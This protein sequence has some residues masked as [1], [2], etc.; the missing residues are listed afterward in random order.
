MNT[1]AFIAGIPQPKTMVERLRTA[2]TTSLLPL[3]LLLAPPAVVEAQFTYMTNNGT[4]IITGYTGPVGPVTIPSTINGQPVTAISPYAFVTR[5]MSTDV[6]P[7]II[8][9]GAGLTRVT[10]PD[11]VTIIGNHAFYDCTNLTRVTIPGSV[12][13][14][15]GEV[16]A[17]CS[18]LNAIT[19]DAL[20]SVYSSLD[21]VVFNKSQTT[22]IE[23]PAGGPG[24]YTIPGSVISI[25]DRAFEDCT[26]LTNITIPN[27]VTS[28]GGWAFS[29]CTNLT[30]A[31]IGNSVV[32]IGDW[33]FDY[34]TSLTNLTIPSSVTSIGEWAFAYCYSLAGATI[35]N[36]VTSIGNDA[37]AWCTSLTNVTIGRSVTNIGN[38]VFNFCTNLTG[39]YFEG[40]AP[41]LGGP[42]V[43]YE[44][45]KPTVYYLRGT[46]GW[47]PTFGG[48]PTAVWVQVP[49]IQTLPQ[50]Q[51]AEA[52]SAVSLRV[53]AN[54]PLPLFYSW[55]LNA[56]NLLRSG[57]NCQLELTSVRLDQSGAYT[58]VISNVLG[59][60]TSAPAML[61][62]IPPVERRPV[63]GVKVMGEAGSLLSV[64]AADFL[65]PAPNWTPL[66]SVSLTGT[67]QY[68]FD[69][70]QPLPPQRFYR[71]WQT[72]TPGVVPSLDLH[73]VPAITL[74]GTIG[75][76]VRLD[77]INQFGPT[78]AWVTLGTVSLTNA[79]QL[80][81]DV[82]APGQ[83][84]RLYRVEQMP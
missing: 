44:D 76:S 4:I 39:V 14:L 60:I 55:Y 24:S 46:T 63:P 62:V 70:T 67:P 51:T 23:Y 13:N 32:S 3:L 20:N 1:Q 57:T 33:A 83:P 17:A 56:A 61:N 69:L 27:S 38:Y 78:G 66:G 84:P 16:F 43:F 9:V 54:S 50:T 18:S 72:G 73:L 81:F 52:T 12:T 47:G 8:W 68:Y 7:Q 71:T 74:T 79:S 10:I 6:P 29:L 40:N 53:R 5:T 11:S 21:G 35:P 19:V 80:Y 77:Y 31:R 48:R 42:D 45:N 82:S 59:A 36:S 49:T 30:S 26:H 64:D 25:G 37:F 34:C 28:V 41:S 75:Y 2:C 22:L 58:V 15:A 65:R